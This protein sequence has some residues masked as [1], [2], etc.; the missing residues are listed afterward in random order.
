[1]NAEELAA[2]VAGEDWNVL[3]AARQQV[4]IAEVTD[5]L[6]KGIP[7]TWFA[8]QALQRSRAPKTE[9]APKADDTL[10]PLPVSA[11]KRR[12]FLKK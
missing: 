12:S 8:E 3:P 5:A 11:P 2:A 9:D 10:D 4:L 7:A 6:Q 1:M